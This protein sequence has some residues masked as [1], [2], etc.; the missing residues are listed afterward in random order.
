ML[1]YKAWLETRS[2]FLVCLIGMAVLASYYL[3]NESR[4]VGQYTGLDWYYRSLHTGH[5]LIAVMWVAAVMFLMMGGL[6]REKA[7]G[8]SS[9]TLSLPVTRTRLMEV[10]ILFGLAEALMLAIIP[11]FAMFLVSVIA[12]KATSLE[13]AAYHLL[14]LLGGGLV[15]FAFAL[16]VSSLVEGEYTAP[17][18]SFGI[19]FVDVV[20][21][22]DRPLRAI[23][24]WSF[25]LGSEY[26]DKKTQ[27]LSGPLP[28][29]HVT[30]NLLLAALL[31]A[32]ANQ[33]IRRR[34]F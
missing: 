17:A 13:Q 27:L 10:R 25:M 28:W 3:Y 26:L 33:F 1:W 30:A 22:G 29:L 2:R 15:F 16:L 11:W 21:L 8:T 5:G 24:P 34:E 31:V 23:S 19:W 18:V 7:L 6:L 9:L 32:M 14:L 4:G 12:G 20:A